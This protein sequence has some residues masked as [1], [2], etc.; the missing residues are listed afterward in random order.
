MSTHTTHALHGVPLYAP[1]FSVADSELS[2]D[3]PLLSVESCPPWPP[4]EEGWVV[5]VADDGDGAIDDGN[6]AVLPTG[7]TL[8]TSTGVHTLTL[9]RSCILAQAS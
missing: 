1:S 5:G 3:P 4:S 9:N 2:A 6:D 7:V 8:L